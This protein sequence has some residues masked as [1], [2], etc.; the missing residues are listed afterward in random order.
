MDDDIYLGDAVYARLEQHGDVEIYT[1]DGYRKTN[2][3]IFEP[4]VLGSLL[5]WLKSKGL[6]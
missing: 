5:D 4:A 3:V 6:A 2:S 1:S